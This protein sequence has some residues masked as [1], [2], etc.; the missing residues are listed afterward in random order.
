[1]CTEVENHASGFMCVRSWSRTTDFCPPSLPNQR[2]VPNKARQRKL[3][4][5][6]GEIGRMEQSFRGFHLRA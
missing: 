5:M 2:V 3:E 6:D 4:G 1:M